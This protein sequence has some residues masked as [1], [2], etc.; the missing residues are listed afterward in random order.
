MCKLQCGG[1]GVCV[2]A[3]AVP[4]ISPAEGAAVLLPQFLP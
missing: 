4:A 3:A 1:G 2:K